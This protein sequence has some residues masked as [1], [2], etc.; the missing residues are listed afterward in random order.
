MRRLT[1]MFEV[2][3]IIMN[4]LIHCIFLFLFYIFGCV[5]T[6]EYYKYQL[7][8]QGYHRYYDD[9]NNFKLAPI[10]SNQVSK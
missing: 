2:I 1:V 9:N 8:Q 7:A 6:S 10:E 3:C 4:F 5:T